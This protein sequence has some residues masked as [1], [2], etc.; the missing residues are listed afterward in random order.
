ML[1]RG[2]TL[3]KAVDAGIVIVVASL[4]AL[5][6]VWLNVLA[7]LAIKYDYTLDQFQ[8]IAQFM[9]VWIIP[10]IGAS[11][12]LR[13]VYDHLPEAIPRSWIPWPFKSLI[14]GEPI[15]SNE[16]RNDRIVDYPPAKMSGHH[17]DGGEGGD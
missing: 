7:M 10:Y 17:Y 13:I 3:L 1:P 5:M 6:L 8:K 12:V 4:A 9:F 14:Y 11:I 16:D 15:E 2:G